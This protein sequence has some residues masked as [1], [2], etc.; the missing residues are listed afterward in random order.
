MKNRIISV[1]L[2][3]IV[4][5]GLIPLVTV[6]ASAEGSVIDVK[7]EAEFA[8]ALDMD[9]PVA[10]INIISDF[11]VTS[12]CTVQFDK[13]HI[14]N[15]SSVVV[16]V[17]EGVTL[18]VGNKGAIGTFW[19]SYEGDWETPPLPE[20]RMVN[21]GTIIVDNGGWID[22][23]FEENNGTIIVKD[24]AVAMCVSENNGTVIVDGGMYM[25]PQGNKCVNNGFIKVGERGTMISR[26]GCTIENAK[27]GSIQL[28]GEFMCGVLGFDGGVMLF[29]NQGEV[30][31]SGYVTLDYMGGPEDAPMPDMDAIIERMMA[32]LGQKTR[33]ED[34]ED[35]DIFV[36]YEVT[37]YEDIT[38]QLK[39]RTVAGE[40]V[41]GNMDLIFFIMGDVVI[42]DGGSILEMSLFII[43]EDA[44]LTVSGGAELEAGAG[45]FPFCS[46]PSRPGSRRASRCWLHG[47]CRFRWPFRW[48]A[49]R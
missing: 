35:I 38:A 15:Y 20:G 43:G 34:W 8:A 45:S 32:Q 37:S 6:T 44:S 4:A 21:N 19:P 31:G 17:K 26:F 7:S 5:A 18:T 10:A 33:F 42:P 14:N 40:H 39:D 49:P 12:D 11:T 30:T 23:S 28:D 27:S 29:D 1:F 46:S 41:E 48:P 36:Q 9:T 3:V 16:T 47:R 24:G 13:N 25:T 22:A 2:A